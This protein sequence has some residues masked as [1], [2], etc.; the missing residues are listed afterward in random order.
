MPCSKESAL[1]LL[2]QAREEGRL[3]HTH[4]ITGASGSGKSWLAHHLAAEHLGCEP[5]A[6]LAHPDAHSVQPESKS[7]R[8]VIEQIRN[9]EKVIHHK[10][11]LSSHK[12]AMIQDAD[13]LQ[14][15]AA[16]AFLKTLEEPPEGTLIILTSSLPEALLETI[17]SRCVETSL[18]GGETP[19]G[20]QE[21]K[22]IEA[23]G[24]CLLEDASSAIGPAF[25][26]TRTLQGLLM[27]ERQR[28][29]K[30]HEAIFKQEAARYKK[31][32]DQ[33]DW[34]AERENQMKALIESSGLRER[35]RLLASIM[36]ALGGALRVAHGGEPPSTPSQVARDVCARLAQ[37]F[38]IPQLL[39]MIDAWDLM[40]RRLAMN[41]NEALALEAGM[42]EIAQKGTR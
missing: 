26:L 9:L 6:L 19:I 24:E 22:I 23:L 28:I 20:P 38:S 7:R 2:R 8:I 21:E 1:K 3:A 14:P 34:L 31:M 5:R 32:S 36:Q 41:I 16:N 11:L 18:Q 42:L 13:R 27:E 33:A 29:T 25:R 4:L 30:E 12:V 10:P 17:L 37:R 35:E 15:Q 39:G 40:R